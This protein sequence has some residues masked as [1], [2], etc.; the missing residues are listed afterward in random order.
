MGRKGLAGCSNNKK[1]FKGLIKRK[2][3]RER[4]EPCLWHYKSLGRVEMLKLTNAQEA[5][6]SYSW[7]Y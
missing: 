5:A 6:D 7:V 4:T 1:M 3:K 2:V